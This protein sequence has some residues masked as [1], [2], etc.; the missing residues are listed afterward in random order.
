MIMFIKNRIFIAIIIITTL[1]LISYIIFRPGDILLK[2]KANPDYGFN[3]GYYLYIPEGVKKSE[4]KYLLVEPNN[5][6]RADDDITVH[7]KSAEK[8]IQNGVCNEIS[9]TLK[10]P[11]LVPTFSR[12]ES[13]WRIYTHALD[14][15]TLQNNEGDLSRID[16][17]LINMINNAQKRLAKRSIVLEDKV[18]MHG[19]SASGNYTNRFAAIH[20][21]KVKAVASGGVNSMPIIPATR[22]KGNAL[23]FHIGVGE[24]NRITGIDFNMVEYQKVAQFIYMGELDDNDTL[25]YDDA[26]NKK[27]RILVKEVLGEKMRERWEK[28]KLIFQKLNISAEMVMYEGVGHKITTEIKEDIIN[29]FKNNS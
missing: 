29:F 16:I 14:R 1:I 22:W 17:Q 9:K 4:I 19:F 25:P 21:E 28:S 20:P 7:E 12:P 15:D 11:L 2:V 23:P 8:L 24:L 27:E 6:G 18:L 13:N 5:T 3:Y 10:V 26:F